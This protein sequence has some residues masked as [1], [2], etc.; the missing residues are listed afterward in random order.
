MGA[1]KSAISDIS[2]AINQ[3]LKMVLILLSEVILIMILRTFQEA[4][5][6]YNT[7][8]EINPDESSLFY[9]RGLVYFSINEFNLALSDFFKI[10]DIKYRNGKYY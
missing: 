3:N 2:L 10:R 9:K 1:F 5:E 8:I 7:A 4:I 6:D